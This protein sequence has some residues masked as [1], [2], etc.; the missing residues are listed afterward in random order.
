MS[1]PKPLLPAVCFLILLL[2]LSAAAYIGLSHYHSPVE[3]RHYI[4]TEGQ[5]IACLDCHT[6]LK[7][8]LYTRPGHNVCV[9]CHADEIETD[10]LNHDTCGFCHKNIEPKDSGLLFTIRPQEP[11]GALFFHSEA[12]NKI[13]HTCHIRLLEEVIMPAEATPA[14]ERARIGIIGHRF[15]F[16]SEC[17]TC[18]R[19]TVSQE[20]PPTS[21]AAKDWKQ[22]HRIIA[23]AQNC[24]ICHSKTFCKNCHEDSY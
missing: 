11:R 17:G 1:Q 20:T 8:G 23:P 24:R 21:H 16:V 19:D 13:C 18:H 7:N 12:L 15:H 5:G 9:S 2:P 10:I 3:F 14:K 22:S 4:H 6:S